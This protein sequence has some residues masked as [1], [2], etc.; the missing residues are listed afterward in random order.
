[1]AKIVLELLSTECRIKKKKEWKGFVVLSMDLKNKIKQYLTSASHGV[2]L[3]QFSYSFWLQ[4]EASFTTEYD[5]SMSSDV[6]SPEGGSVSLWY[7][8]V[9]SF[10]QSLGSLF[11]PPQAF[12]TTRAPHYC[13][14]VDRLVCWSYSHLSSHRVPAWFIMT[15]ERHIGHSPSNCRPQLP[16]SSSSSK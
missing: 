8:C 16:A 12:K 4:N 15:D 11:M 6:S 14:G 5:F 13:V 2:L 9:H 3:L 10:M 1:M 7:I